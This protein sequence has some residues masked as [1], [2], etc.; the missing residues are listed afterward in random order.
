MMM[1]YGIP[2]GNVDQNSGC[3]RDLLAI[4]YAKWPEWVLGEYAAA[5]LAASYV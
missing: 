2:F 1:P 5:D 4:A 3:G